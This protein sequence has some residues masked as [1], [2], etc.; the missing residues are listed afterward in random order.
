MTLDLL[1]LPPT[2]AEQVAFLNDQSAD[3]Y[4]KVVDRLL[5]SPNYGERWAQYWLDLVRYAETAGFKKD[6]M[7]PDAYKYR[8]YVIRALN[9]DLPYNKFIEAAIGRR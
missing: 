8:D 7:R 6:D 4:L 5:S 3:A 2:P 9:Q 1:G